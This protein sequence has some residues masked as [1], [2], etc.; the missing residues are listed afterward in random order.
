MFSSGMQNY[1]LLRYSLEE[2]LVIL[3]FALLTI[4]ITGRN[5]VLCVKAH[6]WTVLPNFAGFALNHEFTSIAIVVC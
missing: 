4:I 2:V 3:R 6:A 5:L 1:V